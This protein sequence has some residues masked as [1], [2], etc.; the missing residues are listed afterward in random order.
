MS[1]IGD[2]VGRPD[3]QRRIWGWATIAWM[4]LTPITMVTLLASRVWWVSFMSLFANT[5]SCATAWVASNSYER[6]RRVDESQVRARL[7]HIIEHHPDIP[8]MP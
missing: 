7:D 1:R 4:V 6:A 5:A 3:V 2:W 8:E